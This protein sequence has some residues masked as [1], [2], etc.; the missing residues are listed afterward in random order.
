MK[1]IVGLGNPGKKYEATPHNL[2]FRVADALAGRW[3]GRFSPKPRERAEVLETRRGDETVLLVKPLTF[4]N[5]SGEAARELM[6]QRSLQA[7]DLLIVS[8]DFNLE[9]G[10]LRIRE[11][12]SHGGHNGL[13]S[14]IECLGTDD[15]PRLRIG[16]RPVR[17]VHDWTAFVLTSPKPEEREQH[18]HMVELAADAVELWLREGTTAAANRFNG[19]NEFQD[20]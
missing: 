17:P 13:R 20:A 2:G 16:V 15:F 3:G 7:G 6:R 10:R 14:M 9:T 4:M 11:K 5:L 1:M 19:L 12:G 8:D 18:H